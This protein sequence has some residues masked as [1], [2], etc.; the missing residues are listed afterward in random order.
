MK[1]F[2]IVHSDLDTQ[3]CAKLTDYYIDQNFNE[4]QEVEKRIQ[5]LSVFLSSSFI[6]KVISL[7]WL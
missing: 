1:L 4:P 7:S 3:K 2:I 5:K 6:I